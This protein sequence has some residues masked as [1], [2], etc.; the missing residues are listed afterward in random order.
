IRVRLDQEPSRVRLA[1]RSPGAR[2]GAKERDSLFER[3]YRGATARAT[4]AGHGL[5]LPLARHIARLHGGDVV[6]GSRPD[7]DAC[8]TLEAP[9]WGPGTAAGP[10]PP[11]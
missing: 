3:F 6:C 11:R 1:V 2:I 7:E 4:Q 9:A 8:L 10:A 5:G